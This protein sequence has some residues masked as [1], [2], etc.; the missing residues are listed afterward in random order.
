MFTMTNVLVA[1]ITFLVQLIS[2]L[3]F[4][5]DITQK[6]TGQTDGKVVLLTVLNNVNIKYSYPS[7]HFLYL[8]N[9][10]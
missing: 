6:G 4:L 5:S 9:P 2:I 7:I 1:M 3:T 8:L 10:I